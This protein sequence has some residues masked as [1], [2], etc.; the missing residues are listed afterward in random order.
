MSVCFTSGFRASCSRHGSVSKCEHLLATR[1][2]TLSEQFWYVKFPEHMVF[3][4]S[5]GVYDYSS[6]PQSGA[7]FGTKLKSMRCTPW[8]TANR[9]IS[10]G[11]G[12]R[13]YSGFHR[14]LVSKV[15]SCCEEVYS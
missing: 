13:S 8:H 12:G 1:G 7:C 9:G 11:G 15:V 2:K 14:N 5:F 4:F 10:V 3:M 6:L